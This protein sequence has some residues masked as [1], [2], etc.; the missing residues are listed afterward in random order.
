MLYLV[1]ALRPR[2][3]VTVTGRS[4]MTVGLGLAMADIA[5]ADTASAWPDAK[6]ADAYPLWAAGPR[7][8]PS[9]A[10]WAGS[11][12]VD[13][14]G[15]I[16]QILRDLSGPAG[17]RFWLVVAPPGLGKSELLRRI[18]SE[19][20]ADDPRREVRFVDLRNPRP[21]DDRAEALIARFFS[22][23]LRGPARSGL[24]ERVAQAVLG[25]GKSYVCLLDSA[26][27]LS[28][29]AAAEFRQV[30][31][32]IHRATYASTAAPGAGRVALIVASR[33]HA[34]W[35]G[36][37][38]APRFKLLPLAAFGVNDIDAALHALTLRTDEKLSTRQ[39]R[40]VTA[41]LARVSSG[42]PELL[43][44]CLQWVEKG[45]WH[46]MESLG[47]QEIFEGLGQRFVRDRLFATESL[48]PMAPRDRSD[49]RRQLVEDALRLVSPFR[50]VTQAHLKQ[51]LTPG[52][53]LSELLASAAWSIE[54]LWQAIIDSALVARPVHEPWQVIHPAVRKL[55]F[56]YSYPTDQQRSD[57]QLK[58]LAFD[59][60]WS[61]RQIGIEQVAGLAECLWH[62]AS[63]LQLAAPQQLV[64]RLTESA[65]A[66]AGALRQVELAESGDL[67]HALRERLRADA[68]LNELMAAET[69]LVDRLIDIATRA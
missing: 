21:I 54:D 15:E 64:L 20:E 39:F 52:G 31:S 12:F 6:M 37:I 42:L 24:V 19:L 32:D 9:L 55:M 61:S 51:Y 5:R 48:L 69:G 45:H 66:I 50:I 16:E 68:E 2:W 47:G 34:G 43:A 10:E 65:R 4:R 18:S 49:Q 58:A 8:G 14:Q 63:A 28:E 1:C 29:R 23:E 22:P 7:P 33:L 17:T 40:Q 46:Q 56:R 62:E 3:V 53:P 11:E 36:T 26:D 38:P 57:A 27:L 41:S 60:E 59:R 30:F 35:V 44:S 13:R 25:S 67:R